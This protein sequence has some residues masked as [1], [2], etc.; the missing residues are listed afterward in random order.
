[1][2]PNIRLCSNK[3]T[4]LCFYHSS[5]P[6]LWLDASW[7]RMIWAWNSMFLFGNVKKSAS[8]CASIKIWLESPW[9]GWVGIIRDHP[10]GWV[11]LV[12]FSLSTFISPHIPCKIPESLTTFLKCCH[13]RAQDTCRLQGLTRGTVPR[14]FLFGSLGFP[15]FPMN[16]SPKMN[17]P[18]TKQGALRGPRWVSEIRPQ[19]EVMNSLAQ[20]SSKHLSLRQC[21]MWHSS[22]MQWRWT[23]RVLFAKSPKII[24]TLPQYDWLL[25]CNPPAA[26]F[27]AELSCH[28]T[29][30]ATCA[31]GENFSWTSSL[32]KKWSTSSWYFSAE[33]ARWSISLPISSNRAWCSAKALSTWGHVGLVIPSLWPCRVSMWAIQYSARGIVLYIII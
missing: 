33:I 12:S 23:S 14:G 6:V 3:P 29:P 27:P 10:R 19:N 8:C 16:P 30:A 22:K 4:I 5:H 31:R 25:N 11:P 32:A 17:K 7:Y 15:W 9:K 2:N 18:S 1:M 24:K 20:L 28:F 13:Q 26:D 21:A